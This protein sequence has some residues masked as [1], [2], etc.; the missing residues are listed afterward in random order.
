METI[1][2]KLWVLL[3]LV[4]TLVACT[5]SELEV[6]DDPEVLAEYPGGQEALMEYLLDNLEYPQDAYQDG[7]EGK[8][9]VSFLVTEQ[10]E[11]Q[12]VALVRG[13]NEDLDQEALR[14][15]EEMGNW[16]PAENNG[17]QVT[18]KIMLPIKF[19]LG[20]NEVASSS[21]VETEEIFS[22]VEE[23]PH[24][25]A[26]KSELLDYLANHVKY[27]ESAQEA[28]IEGRVVVEFIVDATGEVSQAKV[29]KGVSEELDAEAVRAIEDMPS[30]SPGLQ[31]GQQVNVKMHLPI[32]FKL[33]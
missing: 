6:I 13:V 28:G 24:F 18:V 9:Y 20:G 16:T 32:V 26:D 31:R 19:D 30:W 17:E 27:P 10:G 1:T 4:S 2:Q 5:P 29:V 3:G 25:G 23:P 22:V 15:I 7:I 21:S 12:E 14:V 8:V 11:I 33:D